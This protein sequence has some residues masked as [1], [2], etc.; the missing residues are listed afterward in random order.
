MKNYCLKG[1][2]KFGFFSSFAYWLGVKLPDVKRFYGFVVDDIEKSGFRYLLDIGTGPAD[3]PIMLARSGKFPVICAIDPSLDMLRIA[4]SRSKGLDIRF[5]H[6]SSR[7][8][9]FNKKFD[10]IISSLSFHHWSGKES[11]LIYLSRFLKNGGEIRIYEFEK[12]ERKGLRRYLLS[13]HSVSR[14]DMLDAADK[15][16][17][18][19]R[20]IVRRDGFIMT[21]FY[22]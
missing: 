18:N 6:G 1:E 14:N 16:K 9:P 12:K 10:L 7:Y 22:K 4:R 17:L 20:C 3:I 15:S 2:E 19:V 5:G 8:I 11:S 21:S 13:P